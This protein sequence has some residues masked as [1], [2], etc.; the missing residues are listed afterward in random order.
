L[1][2]SSWRK[3][4]NKIFRLNNLEAKSWKRST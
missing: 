2:S 3:N 1:E 4:S